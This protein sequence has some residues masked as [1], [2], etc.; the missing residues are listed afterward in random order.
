MGQ[1]GTQDVSHTPGVRKGE[2]IEDEEGHEPGRKDTGVEY[3]SERPTGTSNA[4]DMTSIDPQEPI[5]GTNPK[6]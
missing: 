3:K 6:G 4:R 5:T 2:E 1:D